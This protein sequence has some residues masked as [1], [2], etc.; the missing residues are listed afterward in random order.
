[1]TK[2]HIEVSTMHSFLLMFLNV[3]YVPGIVQNS[4]VPVMNKNNFISPLF[5]YKIITCL[6]MPH[7][8][9]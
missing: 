1:M 8:F 2:T 3:Y 4:W 6:Y 5:D 7:L 9:D